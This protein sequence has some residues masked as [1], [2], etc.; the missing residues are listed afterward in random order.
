MIF[1]LALGLLVLFLLTCMRYSQEEQLAW[2]EV[3]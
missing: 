2:V 1:Q 3:K